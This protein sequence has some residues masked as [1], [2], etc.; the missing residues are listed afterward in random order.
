MGKEMKQRFHYLKTKLSTWK[1]ER[2]YKPTNKTKLRIKHYGQ[3]QAQMYGNQLYTSAKTIRKCSF[4]K[5]P[6]NYQ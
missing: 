3:V 2:I 1:T 5:T 4:K 6:N